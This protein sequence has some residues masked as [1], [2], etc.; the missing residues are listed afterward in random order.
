MNPNI[1]YRVQNLWLVSRRAQPFNHRVHEIK[2]KIRLDYLNYTKIYQLSSFM[3][4]YH[5]NET[6]Q[7]IEKHLK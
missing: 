1:R 3:I 4:Q 6:K 7:K 2:R 5:Y